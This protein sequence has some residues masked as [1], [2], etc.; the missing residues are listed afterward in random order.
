MDW[1]EILGLFG[2]GL[3]AASFVPQIIKLY[4]L[5]SAKE[6]SLLFTFF[7]FCGGTLWLVYG[8]TLSLLAVIVTNIINVALICLIIIAKFKY[9]R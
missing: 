5:K 6:I 9:G 8:L 7:Q 1:H 2:G 4:K 3:I